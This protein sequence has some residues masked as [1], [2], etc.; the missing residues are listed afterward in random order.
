[1]VGGLSP[2]IWEPRVTG[3]L[4]ISGGLLLSFGIGLL[5]ASLA[6]L[7]LVLLLAGVVV[8]AAGI[9]SFVLHHRIWTGKPV[10]RWLNPRDAS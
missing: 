1:M 5:M 8:L 2:N 4:K 6:R 3:W 9:V 10:P 7:S